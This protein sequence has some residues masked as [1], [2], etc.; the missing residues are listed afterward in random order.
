MAIHA[1]MPMPEAVPSKG[2]LAQASN[3]TRD[4]GGVAGGEFSITDSA[5]DKVLF[6]VC[7]SVCP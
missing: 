5:P 6:W 4:G 7:L 1:Q 3:A 2:S